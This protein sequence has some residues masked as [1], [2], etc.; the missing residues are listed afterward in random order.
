MESTPREPGD[1]AGIRPAGGPASAGRW[2]LT[3]LAFVFYGLVFGAAWVW[4]ALAGGS[5]FYASDAAQLRGT[6]PS[7]DVLVGAAAGMIA[8]HLS[9]DFTRCSPRSGDPT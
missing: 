1:G 9:R 8:V 3:Q 2:T 7:S 4:E 6:S 5:I